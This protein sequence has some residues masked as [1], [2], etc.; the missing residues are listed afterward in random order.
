M[1]KLENDTVKLRAPE[2]NDVDLLYSWENNVEVWRVSNT[3]APFSKHSLARYIQNYQ[4]D[5]YQTKQLRLIID[6]KD[7]SSLMLYPVGI[8]DLFDYDPFH[9]RA[10][11]GILIHS[12]EDRGKGYASEA[13]G[14]LTK[15]A[16]EYLHLHQLYCN[17]AEN[18]EPSLKLF[19]RHE[20]EVVGLKK[21]W[22]RS[23]KGWI[24]EYTLQRINPL[25]L[26]SRC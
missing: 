26:I 10:G 6:A 4:L 23:S 20:F 11:V 3:L 15:Y 9:Q 16:F 13:L 1:T 18:N 7:Q 2:L 21:D 8:I 12:T 22:L 14:L 25:S 17:I 5:I 19:A 24:G